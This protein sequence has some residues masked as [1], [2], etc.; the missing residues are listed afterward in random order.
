MRECGTHRA[1]SGAGYQPTAAPAT[2]SGE[3]LPDAT[4][5]VRKRQTGRRQVALTREPGDLPSLWSRAG[6]G[7]S[8]TVEFISTVCESAAADSRPFRTPRY[9]VRRRGMSDI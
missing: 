2:V 9:L 1:P 6:R 5:T 3:R 7:A 4:D 8:A